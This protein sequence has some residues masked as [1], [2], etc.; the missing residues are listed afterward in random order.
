[1]ES[2]DKRARKQYKWFI[3]T[4]TLQ[5]DLSQ[6]HKYFNVKAKKYKHNIKSYFIGLSY[7]FK[8]YG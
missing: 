2:A 7:Y 1:M 8:T 5:K 3:E 6:N 4:A